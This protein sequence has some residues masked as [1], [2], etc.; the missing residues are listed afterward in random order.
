[1]KKILFFLAILF[2]IEF[3]TLLDISIIDIGPEKSA[4]ADLTNSEKSTPAAKEVASKNNTDNLIHS[5][6]D[7]PAVDFGTVLNETLNGSQKKTENVSLSPEESQGEPSSSHKN[8][9]ETYSEDSKETSTKPGIEE[10]SSPETDPNKTSVRIETT[11]EKPASDNEP[12]P[13]ATTKTTVKSKDKTKADLSTNSTTE[14]TAEPSAKPKTDI[15]TEPSTKPKTDITT[16]PSAKPE[17]ETA[18]KAKSGDTTGTPTCKH[19]WIWATHSETK[20]IPE[21][22]HEVP[23]YDDGWDEAVTVQKIYCPCCKSI[24]EDL[25]DYYDRDPCLGNFGHITVIDHYIHHEPELLYYDTIVDE[26]AHDETITVKDYQYCS[27]CG[28]RK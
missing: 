12:S 8:A 7:K 6:D 17:I 1:M 14:T 16:E 5:Q 11:T 20:H 18:T 22:S 21:V 19:T 3:P 27:K 23:I 4:G 28:E 10:T 26:P 9:K 2:L 25:D 24:Y 13:E 15:T